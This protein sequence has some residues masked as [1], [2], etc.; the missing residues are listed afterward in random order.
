[1]K[2]IVYAGPAYSGKGTS[3]RV[4]ARALGAQ[5][6]SQAVAPT[7]EILAFRASCAHG[8]VEVRTVPGLVFEDAARH[9]A[10]EGASAVVFV[11]DGRPERL[12]ATVESWENLQARIAAL[13]AEQRPGV[14]LQYNHRDAAGSVTIE[15]LEEALGVQ[16]FLVAQAMRMPNPHAAFYPHRFETIA[17]IGDGV[18]AAFDAAAKVA[19]EGAPKPDPAQAQ[20]AMAMLDK[21]IVDGLA[22]ALAGRPDAEALARGALRGEEGKAAYLAATKESFMAAMMQ[23]LADD[24]AFLEELA[25]QVVDAAGS[26][27]LQDV[28][29]ASCK[30]V[31]MSLEIEFHD[32]SAKGPFQ[33]GMA[34][35]VDFA[36]VDPA[37]YIKLA[38]AAPDPLLVL[39][40]QQCA[41]C[42]TIGWFG[43]VIRSGKLEAI[44]PV[45]LSRATL[46]K[47]H[48]VTAGVALEAAR[49]SGRRP[50]ELSPQET[51][52]ILAARLPP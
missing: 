46:A 4:V 15:A 35:P 5:L 47:C 21:Q 28:T 11:A 44:W 43:V 8:P 48:L 30:H 27:I 1:M 39:E 20:F 24:P 49:L 16:R 3:L 45:A 37:A 13:G 25:G 26:S 34:L 41:K 2:I 7:G 50:E 23:R 38:A 32:P 36:K 6:T 42:G 19:Y 29:C 17:S 14:V 10:L 52:Q 40:G 22:G 51:L 9:A 33:V 12:D 31:E 18:R